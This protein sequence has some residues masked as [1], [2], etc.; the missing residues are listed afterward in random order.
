M[1]D[2]YP[3]SVFPSHLVERRPER[4]EGASGEDGENHE[5]GG[6]LRPL[7]QRFEPRPKPPVLPVRPV[8][9]TF[10]PLSP[11]AYLSNVCRSRFSRIVNP[12][13]VKP[14]GL[15]SEREAFSR[16]QRVTRLRSVT[17]LSRIII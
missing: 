17:L 12:S 11:Y 6:E 4:K 3:P 16:R 13:M 10:N 2:L 7:R 9:D 1:F 14:P 5:Y 8:A 15:S